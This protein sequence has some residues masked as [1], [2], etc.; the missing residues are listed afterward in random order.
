MTRGRSHHAT[1]LAGTLV[2]GFLTTTTS[3]T[4]S[5]SRLHFDFSAGIPALQEETETP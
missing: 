5:E 3:G 4:S 2:L 1:I